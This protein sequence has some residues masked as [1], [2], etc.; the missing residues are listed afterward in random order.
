MLK[1]FEREAPQELWALPMD[2]VTCKPDFTG[3]IAVNFSTKAECQTVGALQDY[4]IVFFTDKSKMVCGV[5]A[6]GFLG[7]TK[8]N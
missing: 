8:R 2:H 3:N 1:N 7:Y 4:D 5:G 6:L